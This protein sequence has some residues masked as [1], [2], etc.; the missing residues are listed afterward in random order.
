MKFQLKSNIL[1]AFKKNLIFYDTSIYYQNNK[2][3][4]SPEAFS[5][6]HYSILTNFVLKHPELS[7]KKFEM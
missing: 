7:N 3:S 4:F 6:L 1:Y 2:L 5:I